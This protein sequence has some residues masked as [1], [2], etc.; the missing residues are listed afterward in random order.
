M[1]RIEKKKMPKPILKSNINIVQFE[2]I[3]KIKKKP[4]L[5]TS[6]NEMVELIGTKVI[7]SIS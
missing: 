5:D 3:L 4:I 2:G 6:F 1:I 7:Q